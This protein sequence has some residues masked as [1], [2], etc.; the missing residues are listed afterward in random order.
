ME[1]SA[2]GDAKWFIIHTYSGYENKVADNIKTIVKNRNMQDQILD[3]M[4]PV[5]IVE[6]YYTPDPKKASKKKKAASE[7]ETVGSETEDGVQEPKESKQEIRVRE[8]KLYPSYVFVKVVVGVVEKK[9]EDG[10]TVREEAM[11]DEAWYVIRN[12]RGCTG[13]VGP[14][15]KPKAL[16]QDEV[17]SM[18]IEKRTV[19]FPFQTGDSVRIAEGPF[20]DYIGVVEE[21]IPDREIAVVSINFMGTKASDEFSFDQLDPLDNN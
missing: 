11:S 15:G 21:I 6:E 9:T 17:Y 3:V 14:E 2:M 18:G 8:R 12:T 1:T 7:E 20:V 5:E 13:F 16:T 4:I 10:G 19:I